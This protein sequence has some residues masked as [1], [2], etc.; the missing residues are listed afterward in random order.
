VAHAERP[1]KCTLGC[2]A[3]G[4]LKDK[5]A[6]QEDKCPEQLLT[7]RDLPSNGTDEDNLYA[8]GLIIGIAEHVIGTDLKDLMSDG[9][10]I[11]ANQAVNGS[12]LCALSSETSFAPAA[13][14]RYLPCVPPPSSS[15]SLFPPRKDSAP[16]SLP[17][18]FDRSPVARTTA[19]CLL[20]ATGL[21]PPGAADISGKRKSNGAGGGRQF[22]LPI[23]SSCPKC[24]LLNFRPNCRPSRITIKRPGVLQNALLC[25]GGQDGRGIQQR[26]LRK[27][28]GRD[29]QLTATRALRAGNSGE[30]PRG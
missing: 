10:N 7:Y 13:L 30:R 12:T 26:V 5:C 22:E 24:R 9:D 1:D 21:L 2:V 15:T 17:P 27:R 25:A 28:A 6:E 29:A 18:R 16:A 11:D 4:K 3:H 19:S 14:C 20:P 23:I 8:D